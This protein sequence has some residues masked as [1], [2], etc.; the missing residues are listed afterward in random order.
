M[1]LLLW[2]RFPIL[3]QQQGVWTNSNTLWRHALWLFSCRVETKL[4]VVLWMWMSSQT[5]VCV[6]MCVCVLYWQPAILF[7]VYWD[8][9]CDCWRARVCRGQAFG[10]VEWSKN[11]RWLVPVSIRLYLS[12]ALSLSLTHTHARLQGGG[13]IFQWHI[14]CRAVVGFR[15]GC[16]CSVN[17]IYWS[18]V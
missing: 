2:Q 16:I 17:V 11:P 15:L 10:A 6:G 12:L 5:Q 9:R 18:H 13:K 8:I 1:H 14:T 7:T 3:N 4:K